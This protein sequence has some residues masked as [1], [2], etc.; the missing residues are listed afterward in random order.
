MKWS[1]VAAFGV[2]GVLAR[3]SLSLVV[4][5]WVKSDLPI[6]TTL[7]NILGSFLIGVVYALVER[8]WLSPALKSGLMAGFLG[9]FT[10]FS[11]FSL[12]AFT[13][14]ARGEIITAAAYALL[15][16]ALGITATGFGIWLIR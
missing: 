6:A 9:G 7:I 16:P 4:W 11:A 14:F 13:L 3:Y 2:A 12:E 1:L 8:E 5:R 15:L 10:T